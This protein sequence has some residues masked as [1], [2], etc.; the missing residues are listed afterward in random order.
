MRQLLAFGTLALAS[1]FSTPAA[2]ID[3][4]A[5]APALVKKQ[6]DQGTTVSVDW[7]RSFAVDDDLWRDASKKFDA[8]ALLYGVPMGTSYQ[9]YDS[10]R[11]RHAIQEGESLKALV[12]LWFITSDLSDNAPAVYKECLRALQRDAGLSIYPTKVTDNAFTLRIE[13]DRGRFG[14]D[15]IPLQYSNVAPNDGKPLPKQIASRGEIDI[16]VNRG[17]KETVVVVKSEKYSL[18]DS[19]VV[20]AVY[21]PAPNPLVERKSNAYPV[22][23][24]T[25]IHPQRACL[26]VTAD[27]I[28]VDA[29]PLTT[30]RI[31][32]IYEPT[33]IDIDQNGTRAC[34]TWDAQDFTNG[35]GET[36]NSS[37]VVFVVGHTRKVRP[38]QS[39]EASKPK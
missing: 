32:V 39:G 18:S 15:K 9:Q 37:A 27:E 6:I 29:H 34:G 14:P 31:G 8:A 30:Q 5:C 12:S 22:N 23:Y 17:Q 2:A 21:I 20:P 38:S 24:R 7:R 16:P 11:S 36:A 13:Y 4:Q 28:I 1:V 35:N 10:S 19:L 26:F 33:I 25:G 3:V